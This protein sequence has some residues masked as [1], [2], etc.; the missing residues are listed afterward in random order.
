[1]PDDIPEEEK[2]RRVQDITDL[3]HAICM[4]LN[5]AFVGHVEQVLVEGRSKKSEADSMGRTETNRTVVFPSNGEARGEYV[6]VKIERANSAT[7]MGKR[8]PEAK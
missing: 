8:V 1:M 4:D 7:L 2:G 3:Q 6:D 5:Q